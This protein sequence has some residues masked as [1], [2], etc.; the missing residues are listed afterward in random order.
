MEQSEHAE[1]GHRILLVD[2][3]V[4]ITG[5][6][7][8][9]LEMH[10]YQVTTSNDSQQAMSLFIA[11][12]IAFDLVITDMTLPGLT[13]IELAT[14]MLQLRPDLPV[15]LC[16]GYIDEETRQAVIDSG[17]RESFSKPINSRALIES[18]STLLQGH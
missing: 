4:S 8:E 18:V 12:P 13:G 1:T 7:S 2:D 5:Y 15:I 10:D 16:S 17:I 14:G 9:L 3:E 6:L 11:D